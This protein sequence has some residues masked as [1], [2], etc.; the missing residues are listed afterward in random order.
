MVLK[1]KTEF[2]SQDINFIQSANGIRK[3]V[4]VA[5]VSANFVQSAN[6]EKLYEEIIPADNETYST[7]TPS[8]GNTWIKIVPTGTE[9]YTEI[10]G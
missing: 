1:N 8:S 5:P 4:G 9:T 2:L 3:A 6:G 7:I 10:D